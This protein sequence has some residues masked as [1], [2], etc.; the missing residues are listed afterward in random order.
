[1]TKINKLTFGLDASFVFSRKIN[2]GDT[3]I[4]QR[5]GKYIIVLRGFIV[6]SFY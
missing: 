6:F 4:P 5:E 3:S 2:S 1:M